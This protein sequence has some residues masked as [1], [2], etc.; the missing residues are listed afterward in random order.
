MTSTAPLFPDLVAVIDE[1][2]P[3]WCHYPLFIVAYWPRGRYW[4]IKY[5]LEGDDPG[6][7]V[8]QRHIR[9]LQTSGWQ[10][11]TVMRLPFGSHPWNAP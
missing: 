4:S 9:E 10:H 6:G 2:S 1:P 11:V 8:M 7:L 3:N 5:A